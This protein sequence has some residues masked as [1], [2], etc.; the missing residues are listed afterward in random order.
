MPYP[1]LHQLWHGEPW[2]EKPLYYGRQLNLDNHQQKDVDPQLKTAVFITYG[3]SNAANSG[4]LDYTIKQP[5]FQFAI[6]TSYIY[7]DPSLGTTGQKGSVWGILG[8]RLIEKGLYQQVVFAN[9]AWGNRSISQ[10]KDGHYLQYLL[11][12]YR[13]LIAKYGRVDAIL[14]HQGESDNHPEGVRTYYLH[15]KDFIRQLQANGVYTPV[16]L[17]RTSL[18]GE[19]KPSNPALIAVQNQLIADLD[20]VYEG[21]NTDSLD[22]K[23]YRLE[24][25][26]HFSHQG[27]DAFANLWMLKLQ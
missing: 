4:A 9:C 25:Y 19:E 24:D 10:L 8:D 18:C 22:D 13:G 20:Q 26:C 12:N 5:V 7:Q 14:Y 6:G 16:Y 21:P 15:F 2:K 1:L 27:L 17:A 3:Q 23:K 11:H